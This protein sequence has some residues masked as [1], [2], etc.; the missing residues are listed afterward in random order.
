ME[1]QQKYLPN[2]HFHLIIIHNNIDGIYYSRENYSSV[3][4]HFEKTLPFHHPTQA[5]IYNNIGKIY[6]L[7]ED[8]ITALSH[9]EKVLEIQERTLPSNHFSL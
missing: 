6:R 3:L 1:I 7:T 9:Y 4:S 2:D 8:N 5:I